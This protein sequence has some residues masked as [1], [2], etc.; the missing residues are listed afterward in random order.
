M[1]R[2]SPLPLYGPKHAKIKFYYSYIAILDKYTLYF[3]TK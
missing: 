2:D 1:S 3:I